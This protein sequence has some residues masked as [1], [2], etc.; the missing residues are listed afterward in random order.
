MYLHHKAQPVDVCRELIGVYCESYKKDV[1]V[2]CRQTAGFGV[3]QRVAYTLIQFG[4]LQRV[5][6]TLIHC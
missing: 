5:A 4:V 1:N 3:L 2:T 6:Y